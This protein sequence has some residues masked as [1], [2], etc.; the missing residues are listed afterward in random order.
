MDG[1]TLLEQLKNLSDEP[2]FGKKRALSRQLVAGVADVRQDLLGIL[3]GRHSNII[4]IEA[5]EIIGA[6]RDQSFAPAVQKLAL[7]N[8]PIEVLQ[9]AATVLGKLR[10]QDTFRSLVRL[11]EHENPNVRLGAIYGLQAFGEKQAVRHLL[12]RL[13]DTDHV[14]CWW[15]SP[16][17]G[18]YTVGHEASLAIDA[19]TGLSLRGDRTAIRKWIQ[20]TFK[21]E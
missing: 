12:N 1:N 8:A 21:R 19:L 7:S 15:P 11:L 6:S 5:L 16:K 3:T 20:D 4:T 13:D 14:K 10:S 2:D 9:T 18:G 17:A